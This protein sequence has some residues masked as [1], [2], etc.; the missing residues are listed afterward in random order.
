MIRALPITI[1][2]SVTRMAPFFCPACG[3]DRVALVHAG[4]RWVR[5]GPVGVL[6]WRGT[7]HHVT[8][9]HCGTEHPAAALDVLTSAELA[10]LLVE[11]AVATTVMT[12]RAG[13]RTDPGLRR[14]AVQHIRT[15]QPAYHQA[16]LD[17]D[18]AELDPANVHR[19]V[20]PLADALAAEGKEALVADMV[21]VALAAHT[22]TPHQRWL[23]EATGHGLGLTPVHVTGIISAVAA[24]VE[25]AADDPA[26]RP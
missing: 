6:P 16:D 15:V 19:H 8:C 22:I 20:A 17:R 9:I 4:R 21:K 11:V 2:S 25:P 26:D 23:L 24:A 1:S 10:D 3:G 18:L 5:V 12:V 7:D 14:R 13:C